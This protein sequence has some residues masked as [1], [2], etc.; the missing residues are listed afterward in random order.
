MEENSSSWFVRHEF[1][2]RRVHSLLGLVPVGAFLCIHLTIN[3]SVL[4]GVQTFQSNVDRI[5]ALG[6]FLQPVEWAFIFIPILFHGI[7]GLV[8]YAGGQDNTA[9]YKYARN[10]RYTLQR[11]TGLLA[12]VFILFH[13]WQMHHYGEAI[14]G[15]HFEP[16]HATSSAAV[17]L[18]AGWVRALYFTGSLLCIYHLAN[19]LWTMGITWGIWASPG[20]QKRTEYVCGAV[21]AGLFALMITALVGFAKVDIPKAKEVENRLIEFKEIQSGNTGTH[22]LAV[23]K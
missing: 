15:G 6:P 14:G 23:G 13:V 19:G 7:F 9:R 8:I 18:S 20:S 4:I 10:I 17:V 5:H 1:F 16:E 12:L 11:V 2:L 22:K 21:G 3:A